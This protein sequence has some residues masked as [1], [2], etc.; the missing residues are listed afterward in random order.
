MNASKRLGRLRQWAGEVISSKDKSNVTD[1]TRE[2]EDDIELRRSGIQRLLLVSAQ[3]HHVL[4]KKKESEALDDP[5][6][7]LPR[8]SMGIVM[9]A[10]GEEFGEDSAFGS[11]LVKFGRAHCK[12]ATLQEAYAL[13]LQDSFVNALDHFLNEIK[14]Y[15]QERKK[16]ETRRLN[17][18]AVLNKMEKLKGS[19][20]EKDRLD[21]EDELAKARSRYEETA[22]DVRA[23]IYAI[24]E[25]EIDQQRELTN[26]LD[27]ELNFAEQYV[28]VLRD[29]KMNWVDDSSASRRDHPRPT[30][31][32]HNFARSAELEEREKDKEKD[33]KMSN[34]GSV[35]SHKSGRSSV[36]TAKHTSPPS[37][38]DSSEA[39]VDTKPRSRKSSTA[40]RSRAGSVVSRPTS[41]ASRKRSDSVTTTGST[42][43]K[44]K[45]DKKRLSVAGWTGGWRKKNGERLK[46]DDDDDNDGEPQETSRH[47]STSSLSFM[48]AKSKPKSAKS[49][50]STS[51]VAPPRTLRGLSDETR[52][53]VRAL[54]DF[55]G[56]SDELTF[57]VG[58]EIVVVN[59]V[60]DEWW[61]GELGGKKGLFPTSYTEPVLNLR[62]RA[63]PPIPR[64]ANT[65]NGAHL[66]TA[67]S[68]S[69]STSD[70]SVSRR[71]ADAAE[72]PFGD[73][74]APLSARTPSSVYGH[75]YDTESLAS[76][77]EDDEEHEQAKLMPEHSHEDE[78]DPWTTHGTRTAPEL[79]R[80][81]TDTTPRKAPPPPPPRRA[82]VTSSTPPIG[83]A[84]ASKASPF[85]SS[86]SLPDSQT[87][88][89]NEFKQ[90]PFKTKG[91]CVNCFRMHI[92]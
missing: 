4:S 3:Y 89:C 58:D 44:E 15:E 70:D 31:P 78:D 11:S 71:M 88:N 1:E 63:S 2:L 42:V 6:K 21:A 19:K 68:S 66:S 7:Y 25:N 82:T 87:G 57:H 50:P 34:L 67:T 16:L 24:Q 91:M 14:D 62:A 27:L 49:T 26:F 83:A 5:D 47:G 43:E 81:P 64:R 35:R 30:G 48:S 61:M 38:D 65:F 36:S 40:A 56:S 74:N 12:I 46:D 73:H 17:Y 8:D 33:K 80:R 92:V 55:S 69:A 54:Y 59:E 41:R 76:S 72:H 18:D 13:T 77:V 85:F 22:E 28:E 52:K 90:N 29:V 10:H 86:V 79:P 32:M 9:I 75:G 84:T 23:R 39:E 20:K 51:P 37:N 60:L 53:R 45:E